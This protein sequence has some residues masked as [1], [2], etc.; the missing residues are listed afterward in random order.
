LITVVC[1]W[2][3]THSRCSKKQKV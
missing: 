3:C 1:P 2:L